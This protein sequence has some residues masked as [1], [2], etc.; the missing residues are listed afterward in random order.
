MYKFNG[1]QFTNY[2]SILRKDPSREN[3]SDPVKWAFSWIPNTDTTSKRHAVLKQLL[4][5]IYSEWTEETKLP[6]PTIICEGKENEDSDE[7]NKSEEKI[8][9]DDADPDEI[10]IWVRWEPVCSYIMSD[11]FVQVSGLGDCGNSRI[12]VEDPTPEQIQEANELTKRLITEHQDKVYKLKSP[13]AFLA[14]MNQYKQ[15][16]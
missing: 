3:V 1:E 15:L 6:L 10:L 8:E 4:Q 5:F 9:E 13:L 2:V 12:Y 11:T 16:G 7:E 14:E